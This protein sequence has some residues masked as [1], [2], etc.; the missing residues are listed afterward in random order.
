VSEEYIAPGFT[1][2]AQAE[3]DDADEAVVGGS[4][5]NACFSVLATVIRL[6]DTVLG[7]PFSAILAVF[8][9]FYSGLQVVLV[10]VA[11]LVP[12]TVLGVDWFTANSITFG[13]L[14]LVIPV[15]IGLAYG[16]Q[17]LLPQ[18]GW[19]VPLVPDFNV[20]GP[21]TPLN[22]L[23][24]VVLASLLILY[25][26]FLDHV[27]GIVAVA[28]RQAGTADGDDPLFGGFID[29]FIDKAFFAIS[30]WTTLLC[31]SM[32]A[33]RAI[34]NI[35]L[36]ASDASLFGAVATWAFATEAFIVGASVLL[37]AYEIMIATVRVTDYFTE[38]LAPPKDSK[39]RRRLRAAMEGKLKQKMTSFG[40]AFL[41]LA[42][43]NL[44]EPVLPHAAAVG[45]WLLL[46]ACF[47]AHKSLAFKLDAYPEW[48]GY[49]PAGVQAL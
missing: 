14:F 39:T 28:Q 13:R 21:D 43:P 24:G 16:T 12:R 46:L 42:V 37:V 40:L 18:G 41:A 44:A 15:A 36:G 17:P 1:T 6:V 35:L 23:P 5:H 9:A 11:K 48:K 29:A 3:L 33:S 27:D 31:T 7:V 19:V 26:D 2:A 47:M 10:P 4:R 8:E 45:G 25:H 32:P 34:I 49:L 30:I 20:S 22:R 38:K